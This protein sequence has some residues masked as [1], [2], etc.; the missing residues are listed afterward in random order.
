[1]SEGAERLSMAMS[2]KD[3]WAE[4]SNSE[5][6]GAVNSADLR[7]PKK[8]RQQAAFFG[9]GVPNLEQL[10]ENGRCD[11]QSGACLVPCGSLGTFY[12][13]EHVFKSWKWLAS[14]GVFESHSYLGVA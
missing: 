11:G 3:K 13:F 6:E 8:A 4:G 10:T 2:L 5:A 14:K 1:M 12:S 7:N 9:C